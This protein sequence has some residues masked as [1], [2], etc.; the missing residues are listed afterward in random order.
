MFITSYS[1]EQ[2]GM[3]L[4]FIRTLKEECVWHHRLESIHHAR[5]VTGRWLR[6]YNTERPHQPLDYQV[7]CADCCI[8]CATTRRHYRLGLQVAPSTASPASH[9]IW[10]IPCKPSRIAVAHSTCP[11]TDGRSSISRHIGTSS[12]LVKCKRR[13]GTPLDSDQL[14]FPL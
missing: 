8:G 9:P 1:Q 12:C 14:W 5:D 6:H 10:L 11:D 3:I 4:R 7:V 13:S 2:N